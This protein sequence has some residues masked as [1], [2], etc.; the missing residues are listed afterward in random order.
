MSRIPTPLMISTKD[1]LALM[2]SNLP[3]GATQTP[4]TAVFTWTAHTPEIHGER[5]D[6]CDGCTARIASGDWGDN[7]A[8]AWRSQDGAHWLCPYCYPFL[9][10]LE[11]A[12][13][14][15]P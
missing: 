6:Q 13:G 9:Q 3:L 2:T 1:R 4:T 8:R 15:S 12:G 10:G 14:S 11:A 5:H 7:H